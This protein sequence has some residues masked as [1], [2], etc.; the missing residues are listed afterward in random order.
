[1]KETT[2]IN[3]P[4]YRDQRLEDRPD[5]LWKD[6]PGIEMYFQISNKGRVKR[7]ER[8]TVD[9][10][11]REFKVS[12]KIILPAINRSFNKLK[13]DFSYRF[14]CTIY[15][16]N[17]KYS[18]QVQRMVYYCFIEKFDLKDPKIYIVSFEG[19]GLDIRPTNLLKV[20]PSEHMKHSFD[21]GRR[22]ATFEYDPSYKNNAVNASKAITSKKI[23]QYNMEGQYIATFK[24]ISEAS[25]MTNVKFAN[26]TRALTSRWLSPGGF[27]WRKGS[28]KDFSMETQPKRDLRKT[29][30]KRV[31][32]FD[33]KGNPINWYLALSE[34]AMATSI[35]HKSITDNIKGKTPDAGGFIWKLGH[36]KEKLDLNK[37]KEEHGKTDTSKRQATFISIQK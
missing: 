37:Y 33:L 35:N 23:S 29:R 24:S 30:G 20:T 1:M 16:N 36:I 8:L 9:V 22:I 32:Q 17:K 28:N 15:I 21:R 6:I 11:G 31:T 3:I 26:I 14:Q 12:E 5:E 25:R 18:F 34:A 4:P 19:N 10:L 2:P 27:Y 13:N 7:K